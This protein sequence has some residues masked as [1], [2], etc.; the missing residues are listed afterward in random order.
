M[1]F[2]FSPF[3]PKF[4]A[5][6]IQS[7]AT[8]EGVLAGSNATGNAQLSSDCGSSAALTI[9]GIRVG[10]SSTSG[11]S[12][13]VGAALKGLYGSLTINANGSYTYVID[14]S[15]AAVNA[16]ALGECL[17]ECFTYTAT[18]GR[19]CASAAIVIKVNGA[20]DGATITGMAT[21]AV[22]E[23]AASVTATGQL[24]VSD[25][26]HGQNLAR[27]ISNQAGAYGQF[28]IAANGAWTYVLNNSSIAV[29][30]LASGQHVTES[31]VVT[32]L[33]GTA[34]RTVVM[35]VT[36]TNDVATICGDT[37]ASLTE[38]SAQTVARGTL[39]VSDR[40]TGE[41]ATRVITN[42]AGTYGSFSVDACGNW[43][44]IMN[45]S[46]PAVQALAEGEKGT[47]SFV[48]WSKDG[49]ARQTVTV[50]V[51]GINDAATITGTA[52]GSVKEDAV[53]NTATGKLVVN[54]VDHF[55][56]TV[57]PVTA[58]AGS[59][60]SFSIAADGTWVYTLNNS[61]ATVQSLA[62]GATL[63][64]S[65]VVYSKDS[66][67]PA[68]GG[69]NT[70][71]GYLGAS[72]VVTVTI[73]G[74]NDAAVITGSSTGTVKEDLTLCASGQLCVSDVDSSQS[75]FLAQ[76]AAAGLYG[77]FSINA[78][79]HWTYALNN[80]AAN[81]Q[82]LVANDMV[83]DTFTVKSIDG[84]QKAVSIT[85]NGTNDIAKITG[86]SSGTVKEDTTLS[87][88]GTLAVADVDRGEAVFRP[89]ANAT[90]TYGSFSIGVDGQWTYALNNGAA[91]V[92]ALITGEQVTD[93]FTVVSKDGTASQVV[94]VKVLGTNDAAIISGTST[95]SVTED[96]TLA[97]GGLLTVTAMDHGLA[98]FQAQAN[99]AGAY[100][101]FGIGSDGHW[102]YALNNS[103]ANVQALAATQH[104][105]DSFTV[106]SADG[107]A[108]QR[109]SVDIGGVND[110][111]VAHDDVIGNTLLTF[112]PGTY[113]PNVNQFNP[114][115]GGSENKLVS[116]DFVFTSDAGLAGASATGQTVNPNGGAG[117]TSALSST[118]T[119]DA[120]LGIGAPPSISM[121]RADG[122]SFA[123]A[124]ANIS[125]LNSAYPHLEEFE[126]VTGYSNG[127][128]I[129]QQ[130]FYV[131]DALGTSRDN[132]VTFSE[133]GFHFVDKV[134]FSLANT[135][136]SGSNSFG[137]PNS[138][139]QYLDNITT[140]NT[141]L[142]AR[143]I[144]VLANDTDVD[145]GA[146]LSLNSFSAFSE[147]GAAITLNANGTL[148]YDPTVS[149]ALQALGLGT[150]VYDRFIYQAQDELGAMSN[151]ATVT[152]TLVGISVT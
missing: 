54:D 73:I 139:S 111:P 151:Q 90:G 117:N 15:N 110:A 28:S 80:A 129:A 58:K 142:K 22:I 87:A 105:S 123:L 57:V 66:G 67:N 11:T 71:S 55:E 109:I 97:A 104:V 16:L 3:A 8:E 37:C 7:S 56:N 61:L 127:V 23:D 50:T 47:D 32:S 128:Q 20:N 103:A 51:N 96:T 30:S 52:T 137:Q 42:Q 5:L 112:S 31:F 113:T 69:C 138:I 95:G 12:G 77:S 76:S 74:I 41:S 2:F 43:T 122:A 102:T 84:T 135:A 14:N 40:D 27:A 35:T 49:S 82:A 91:H 101:S 72:K 44:F 26:D 34:T 141:P 63:T 70:G 39:N 131:P 29:Q 99:V 150:E 140:Q 18:N 114:L 81:V 133:A 145:T 62:E 136:Y 46:L 108:T 59:Y 126:T 106:T 17:Q 116:G 33:D 6:N 21:G 64:E 92:Q 4:T 120:Y 36:G 1:T 149:S 24:T 68:P 13:S 83:T 130:S 65:F 124:S 48:V 89:Q 9:T 94:I 85:V 38:D 146:H 98:G 107:T 143:D 121:S 88:S 45:N 144:D 115:T 132:L 60:G 148:H 125:G 25:V 134:V 152:V 86:N 78:A 118:S 147:L 19:A 79:G 75:S 53:P 93:S 100:G 10:S 119:F